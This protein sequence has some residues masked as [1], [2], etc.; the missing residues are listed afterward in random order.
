MAM[1]ADSTNVY[2]VIET[3]LWAIFEADA[4]WAGLVQPK[5][6]LKYNL[7]AKPNPEDDVR[8]TA[9]MPAARIVPNGWKRVGRATNSVTIEQSYS[10]EIFTGDL[11]T[12]WYYNDV[13]L[14]SQVVAMRTTQTNPGW[15]M[16]T[17]TTFQ[18][19]EMDTGE[20][21]IGVDATSKVPNGWTA[22]LDLKVTFTFD[23]AVTTA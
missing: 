10:L 19:V 4:V 8:I 22:A 14:A 17:G 6:R 12:C 21:S 2:K 13:K 7:R 1:A 11:R 9:D 5:N 20:E 18:K 23:V 16:P 15:S 3:G